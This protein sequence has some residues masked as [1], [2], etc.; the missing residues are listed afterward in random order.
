M[1]TSQKLALERTARQAGCI[2]KV[3]TNTSGE[4][5]EYWT[6]PLADDTPPPKGFKLIGCWVNQKWLPYPACSEL[7]LPVD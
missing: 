1:K 3:Y 2:E 6:R 4:T 5:L 7:F